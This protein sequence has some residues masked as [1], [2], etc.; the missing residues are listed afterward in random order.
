M[1]T[2]AWAIYIACKWI[3][4]WPLRSTASFGRGVGYL[5]ANP[6]MDAAAFLTGD[7]PP[8]PTKQQW[9]GA[10]ANTLTG[11]AFISL[12]PRVLITHSPMLAGWAAMIGIALTLHFGLLDLIALAWRRAGVNAEPLMHQPTR[13]TSLADFR[14]RRW[15]MGFRT[16]AHDFLF[17]PLA[18]RGFSTMIATAAVFAVSG[19]VHD[20][21][22]SLP[23]RGGY[24][25]PTL[26]FI[27]Q[28]AGLLIERTAPMRSIIRR[29]RWVGRAYAY[30]FT[31]A[32][33]PLLFHGPF[34][35]RVI[36]PFIH[37]IGGLS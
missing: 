12:L 28:L 14:G 10:I 36:L 37:A 5:L 29:R 16:L 11:A 25:L 24:G 32:P 2:V 21:V 26:Y 6:G 35:H 1:W 4:W 15:N 17:A 20:A 3:T 8:R 31:L 33:A 9:G 13:A 27:L 22:I 7:A 30:L 23:A 19:I 18:R 34:V